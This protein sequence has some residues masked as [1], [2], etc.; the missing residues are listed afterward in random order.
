MEGFFTFVL[1][2]I[3]IVWLLGR[4][5]PFLLTWWVRR[6]IRKMGKSDIYDDKG[7]KEGNVTI[8]VERGEKKIVDNNVGEYVDYEETK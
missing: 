1:F 5:A 8:D 4:M 3:L 6:K 7:Y 2:F